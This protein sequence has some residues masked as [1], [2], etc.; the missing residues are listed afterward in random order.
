LLVVLILLSILGAI[1]LSCQ[2]IR[3]VKK[4]QL[5]Y[6]P[7][8][9]QSALL[10]RVPD[11]NK[12]L[13]IAPFVVLASDIE[14]AE[15]RIL[16]APIGPARVRALVAALSAD[17]PEGFG[18]KY[19]WLA[20]TTAMQALESRQANCVALASVLVGLGRGLG[21]RIYYAEARARRPET[22]E[23]EQITLISD[24]MVVIVAALSFKIVIDFTGQIDDQYELNP[25]DDL[26]AYAH[27]INNI[28]G[29][30]IARSQGTPTD[31]DWRSALKGFEL[32]GQIQPS[33]GRAWN[34]Q[35]IALTRLDR[36]EEA[37][38]AYRRA[39]ELNSEFGSA[40][41][42]LEI[43]QT[44]AKGQTT[45]AEEAISR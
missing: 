17:L 22:Y 25:I 31:D 15:A 36:F 18:L 4:N 9:F 45:V 44:R 23:F 20:S 16:E 21:W 41:R 39:L 27:L 7:E 43:M 34:N 19:D 42:N 3:T 32:A 24:H 40:R 8:D 30:H 12:N 26:T 2:S 5:I 37:E 35:G 29:Q 11:L 33:L 6:S 1:T 10:E 14:K 13:A 38:V 28:A